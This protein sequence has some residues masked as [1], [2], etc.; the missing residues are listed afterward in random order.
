MVVC[1]SSD[2]QVEDSPPH[3]VVMVVSQ[4]VVFQGCSYTVVVSVCWWQLE[5]PSVQVSVFWWQLEPPSV[6]EWLLCEDQEW[7]DEPWL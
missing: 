1:S 4:W 6:Q 5:P 2:V 7:L 3:S